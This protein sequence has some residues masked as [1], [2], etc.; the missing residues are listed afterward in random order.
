M[1]QLLNDKNDLPSNLIVELPE[2]MRIIE[3]LRFEF[4]SKTFVAKKLNSKNRKSLITMLQT[5]LYHVIH[6]KESD[7]ALNED[8]L[9]KNT[10]AIEEFLKFCILIDSY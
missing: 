5:L 9:E 6:Q 8:N 1:V 4:I 10:C 2:F 7:E 3:R